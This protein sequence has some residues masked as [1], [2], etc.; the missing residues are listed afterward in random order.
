MQRLEEKWRSFFS[1]A[2]EGN[3]VVSAESLCRLS[4]SGLAALKAFVE[5][6]FDQVRV[7]AYVR[8][9]LRALK[10]QW[11]QN[12]KEMREPL[13][14]QALLRQTKRRQNYRFFQRW[15]DAFGRDNFVLRRFDPAGFAG[16]NLL[17]DFFQAAQVELAGEL[18]LPEQEA[19]QSLGTEGV[20]LL[21]AMNSRYPLY[22]EGQLNPE[23][24]LA[25]RQHLFYRLMREARVTPLA[26]DVKFDAGEAER[27]NRRI[28]YVNSLLPEGQAFAGV[29]P[30]EE[31]TALPDASQV[32]ADYAV[33]LVNGLC[34]LVDEMADRSDHLLRRVKA[35]EL[36]LEK[37]GDG[38]EDQD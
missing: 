19:N 9:P 10:S 29:E 11:E 38:G 1:M 23:R 21:L 24:G 27:F 36:A 34:H 28:D 25:G 14:A 8:D 22:R 18:E 13:S 3:W 16:G 5:P 6:Y 26:L 4:E 7:V 17:S 31:G 32:P 30:S 37:R 35:L 20:A 33:E 12:V 15:I 2:E